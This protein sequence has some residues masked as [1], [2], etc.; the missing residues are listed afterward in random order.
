MNEYLIQYLKFLYRCSVNV[1]KYQTSHQ[2]SDNAAFLNY[3]NLPQSSFYILIILLIVLKISQ[4]YTIKYTEQ[5][6]YITFKSILRE[7]KLI[8]LL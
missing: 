4:Y 6:T 3:W 8:I 2:Y 5:R 7:N 1:H